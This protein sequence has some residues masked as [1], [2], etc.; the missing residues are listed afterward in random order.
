MRSPSAGS[1]SSS[2]GAC[3]RSPTSSRDWRTEAMASSR[4]IYVTYIRTTP[5]KL[6]RALTEPEFTRQFWCE[7]W[8]DCQ[9]TKG[10]SWRIMTPDGRVADTGE[11]V[12]IEPRRRLALTWQN[13]LF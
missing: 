11:I 3:G 9:W 2:G 1:A 8:Q 5:E 13:H 12:E 4:F 10:A 6:W 7:T